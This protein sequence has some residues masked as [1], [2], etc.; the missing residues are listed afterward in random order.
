HF[1]RLNAGALPYITGAFPLGVRAGQPLETAEVSV[2]GINLGGV[3]AVHVWADHPTIIEHAV[4]T[5]SGKSLNKVKLAVGN[6]PEITETEPNNSP[7]EAQAVTVPVTINGHVYNGKKTGAAD[8][9]YFR[10][11]AKK[12][13]RL[14]VEVAAARLGSPLDSVVE[15]LD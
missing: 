2:W 10:F 7:A 1:Y 8:E 4:E 5:P 11:R 9:D 15:V 3:H 6:E 13:Q 14:M 12:G